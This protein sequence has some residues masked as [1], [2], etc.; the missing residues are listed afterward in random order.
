VEGEDVNQHFV[1]KVK[2]IACAVGLSFFRVVGPTDSR[3][4][5]LAVSQKI[6]GN[7]N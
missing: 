5:F 1:G 3:V 4:S 6:T 7:Q 2:E